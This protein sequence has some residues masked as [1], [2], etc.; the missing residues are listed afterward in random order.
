MGK[1]LGR[2]ARFQQCREHTLKTSLICLLKI[3]CRAGLKNRELETEFPVPS[4]YEFGERW[5]ESDQMGLA[6]H[7]EK[8]SAWLSWSC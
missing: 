7:S 6:E 2:A 8:S 4:P 3:P 5:K 1:A